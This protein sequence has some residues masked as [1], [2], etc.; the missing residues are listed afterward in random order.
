MG[1]HLGE[2]GCVKGEAIRCPFHYWRFDRDGNVVDI[3][4]AKR[5][6]PKAKLHSW[7]LEE[8]N[9]IIMTHHHAD[10]KP[11][12]YKIPELP[13]LS[14]EGWSDPVV[15]RWVLR[16]RWIDMNE[17]CVDLGHFTAVH[18]TLTVPGSSVTRDGH[19]FGTDSRFQQKSPSGPVEGSLATRDYG[20]GFQTVELGG[21]IDTLMVNTATPIDD[22]F[23]DVV[24]AYR[25]KS[26][27][28]PRKEKLGASMITD[29]I[30]Q[31]ENDLPIWETKVYL[32]R[33]QLCD[34]D[35]PLNDYRKWASQF[36]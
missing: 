33:P 26:E 22:S 28:D 18:G 15:Q 25:V 27:G 21:I 11:P 13:Q 14:E 8:V 32:E 17:N 31:F 36:F 16:S 3:P 19:I 4:Y 29:L 10:G 20:P 2:G 30:Q 1:A 12:T 5:I 7:P 35:G 23:T 6:P 34:G 9:G 24:F